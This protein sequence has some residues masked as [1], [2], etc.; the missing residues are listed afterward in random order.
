MAN[1]VIRAKARRAQ[2]QRLSV[3]PLGSQ[4]LLARAGKESVRRQ[5]CTFCVAFKPKRCPYHRRVQ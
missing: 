2:A 1:R 3:G 4:E 5:P